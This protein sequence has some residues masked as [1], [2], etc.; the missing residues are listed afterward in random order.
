M[1]KTSDADV[2]HLAAISPEEY[3]ALIRYDP[4]TFVERAFGE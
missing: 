3:R 2:R 4:R 1:S